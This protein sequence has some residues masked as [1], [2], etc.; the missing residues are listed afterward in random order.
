MLTVLSGVPRKA[1]HGI[2]QEQT[3]HFKVLVRR[4]ILFVQ[5]SYEYFKNVRRRMTR[6]G[7]EAWPS[8]P[9]SDSDSRPTLVTGELLRGGGEITSE[10]SK[11]YRYFP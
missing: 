11:V 7:A 5:A 2:H 4:S 10:K 3:S 6:R 8:T 9:S 1:T